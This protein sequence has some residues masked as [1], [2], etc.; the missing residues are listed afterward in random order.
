MSFPVMAWLRHYPPKHNT[1]KEAEP[2][3]PLFTPLFLLFI[4]KPCLSDKTD[5]LHMQH[6]QCLQRVMGADGNVAF[7][8]D[9]L[10]FE[11]VRAL[12]KKF[13]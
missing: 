8:L 2:L 4:I 13:I 6:S 11:S 1:E 5:S 7:L 9:V 3:P 10:L 12:R